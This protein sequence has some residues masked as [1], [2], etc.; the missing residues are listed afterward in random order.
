MNKKTVIFYG[1]VVSVGDIMNIDRKGKRP[2]KKRIV[3]VKSDDQQLV[4]FEQR[5][6]LDEK[7]ELNQ[8]VSVHYYFAGSSKG[9]K[10]YNNI[11]AIDIVK[12]GF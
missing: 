7:L 3:G 10:N 5:E 2:L 8:P 12:N 11:I 4:Y 6:K 1:E 9:E